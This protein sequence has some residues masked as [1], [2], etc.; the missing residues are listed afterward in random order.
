MRQAKKSLIQSY[1]LEDQQSSS[2]LP[3]VVGKDTLVP[4][5]DVSR[6]LVKQT[7]GLR[8]SSSV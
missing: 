1:A 3:E 2:R 8:R 5:W 4:T 6:L 7:G